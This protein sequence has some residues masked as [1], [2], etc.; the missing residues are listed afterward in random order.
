M[1]FRYTRPDSLPPVVKN[2]IFINV[3]F[4]LATG[5]LFKD[6][7]YFDGF[8]KDGLEGIFGLWPINHENFRPYQIFTHMFTHA[9]FSHIIFN[10]FALWMFGRVLESVWGSK[11]FL[12]FYLVCGIGSAAA[13]MVVAYFQYQEVL[14][15]M[16]ILKA[17]GQT[18]LLEQYQ[19]GSY[20]AVGASGA[21]MGVMVGFAY[22]FPNTELML[23]FPPIPIKAKWLILIMIAFDLFGGLGK[24]SD[25]VAHW[26]H[27]GGA[28]MGFI[29]V[30]IWNKTN[31]KT[32]Y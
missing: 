27:L 24:T 15:I 17:T 25:G 31:K 16:E 13:H 28:A 10:M 18:E 1:S 32:F 14:R 19:Y 11:K 6:Q 23:L 30:Y 20:Y 9:G 5:F 3:L 12:L 29:L 26:A 4:F 2:L 7:F 22:L 21:V 8:D